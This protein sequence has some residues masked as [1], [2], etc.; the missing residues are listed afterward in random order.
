RSAFNNII[1]LEFL[2]S[3]G[4]GALFLVALEYIAGAV[5][6][7]PFRR[8]F[9]YLAAILLILPLVALPVYFHIHDVFHW[10]HEEVVAADHILQQK[11]AYL[12]IPFFTIRVVGYFAIWI[13]FYLLLTRNSQKQ[14]ATGDA[15]YTKRNIKISA[16]FIPIFAFTLTFSSI[17]WMMSLEPHWFSTIFAVYYFAGTVLASL[18]FGTFLIVWFN[19]KGLL[20]KGLFKD[21]YYS[22]GALL[23]AFINFW[24]YIAFS[25]Y[26][27]IWYANLPEETIWFL[28]RWEGTWM[29]FSIILIL[30][31]FFIPYF[32][33]LSQPSKMDPKRL[34]IMSIWILFAHMINLFWIVLPTFSPDGLKFGWIEIGF[35]ILA[36]GIV[37]VVFNL[38]ARNKNLVPVGD[39]KLQRGIDFRL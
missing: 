7:T 14:D 31:H 1:L 21:H 20:I 32:G 13:I 33:L 22:L 34:K 27:L 16:A 26:L 24:A 37:L 2:T 18:A 3:V 4:L 28:Q 6:S 29:I 25:Q 35:I 19:E 38:A 36:F 11:E 8:I 23:F 5:W 39:P 12:N 10:S 9:E 30:A 15:K 17:D